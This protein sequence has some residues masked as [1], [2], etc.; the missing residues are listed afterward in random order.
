MLAISGCGVRQA[1][2]RFNNTGHEYE[3]SINATSEVD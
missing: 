3:L 1:N 2:K